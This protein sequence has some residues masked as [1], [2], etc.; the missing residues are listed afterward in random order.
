[1]V[2]PAHGSAFPGIT[3]RLEGGIPGSADEQVDLLVQ[4]CLAERRP[5][6]GRL[7]TVLRDHD[8][9]VQPGRRGEDAELGVQEY[10]IPSERA[11][12][13]SVTSKSSRSQPAARR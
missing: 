1:M 8:V 7:E 4:G 13:S 2:Q 3:E 12:G 6:D 10:R 5:G 11:V 9:A